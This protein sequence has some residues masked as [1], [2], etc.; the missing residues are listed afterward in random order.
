MLVAAQPRPAAII[1]SVSDQRPDVSELK[2]PAHRL[3]AADWALIALAIVL[4]PLTVVTLADPNLRFGVLAP[5]ADI[6][7]NE[8]ALLVA[9]G[10]AG[11]AWLRYRHMRYASAAFEASA[12][13]LFGLLAVAQLLSSL[14]VLDTFL[15]LT[16]E[17]PRQAPV[18]AWA[19]IRLIAAALLVRAAW[20]R[21]HLR[22]T[23][24]AALV[25]MV[26]LA[27]SVAISTLL[28]ALEPVLPEALGGDAIAQLRDPSQVSGALPGVGV[29]E[30]VLQLTGVGL[31]AIATVFYAR[32]ARQGNS[33]SV[34][35]LAAGLIL[36]AYSQIHFALFPGAFSGLVSTSDL[37]RV[38][39][40][41]FVAFGIQA[42][43]GSTLDRLRRA[44]IE[45]DELRRAD[46]ARASLAERNRL[47]RE[48]HDGLAQDLWVA[49]LAAERLGQARDMDQVRDIHRELED[50]IGVSIADARESVMALREAGKSGTALSEMLERYVRRFGEQTGLDTDLRIDP[51]EFGVLAPEVSGELLRI[52]QEAL[53]NVRRH[54][55][56]TAVTVDLV[57][58][59]DAIRLTVRDNGIGFDLSQRSAGYGLESMRERAAIAGGT[60]SIE[61]GPAS[62]TV[63]TVELAA[64]GT[65]HG[66]AT[67]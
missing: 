19:A 18:Y 2:P 66:G 23:R 4:A 61:S 26:P 51:P 53:N 28:Y 40:Y 67:S 27:V 63:V 29:L 6:L 16:I 22:P 3:Q 5:E 25:V 60:L 54:A 24:H 41:G 64:G 38:A 9:F 8:A 46:V 57:R 48:V 58:A 31:F 11:L 33:S 59:D 17:A 36:A 56:A 43:F 55:D 44:N 49:K 62:G 15:G 21:M 45:L 32:A 37:L 20:L 7:I 47:A 14:G 39:F 52:A 12:F 35:Y 50:L 1:R 65:S 10:A 13:V 30:L 34:R 42:E